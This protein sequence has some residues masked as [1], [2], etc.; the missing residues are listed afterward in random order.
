MPE[1]FKWNDI[2]FLL[3]VSL[4]LGC[5]LA[6]PLVLPHPYFDIIH[7]FSPVFLLP[8]PVSPTPP[9][10]TIVSAL[11]CLE[12]ELHD[13]VCEGDTC[14]KPAYPPFGINKV[15]CSFR[16]AK[17][18]TICFHAASATF[19]MGLGSHVEGHSDSRPQQIL[20]LIVPYI[21]PFNTIYWSLPQFPH[22]WKWCNTYLPP[23]NVVKISPC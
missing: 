17:I 20:L 11:S 1:L 8:N 4:L 23:L 9:A 2:S 12:F 14:Q 5:F 16:L 6:G 22:L 19:A 21:M 13:N 18:S 3:G 7:I 15:K 10:P